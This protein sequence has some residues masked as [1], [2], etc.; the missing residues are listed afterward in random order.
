MTI[1]TLLGILL[2]LLP[3]AAPAHAPTDP[4]TLSLTEC[5]PSI[6]Q[7]QDSIPPAN[8][9]DVDLP[10]RR[11][12]L[13]L[14][15]DGIVRGRTRRTAGR[16]E[17]RSDRQW[18][19]LRSEVTSHRLER[20]VLAEARA[21]RVAL[22]DD[23]PK[24]LV[25]LARWMGTQG[26]VEEAVQELD[27]VL[28]ADPDQPDAL[29]L[30]ADP[31]MYAAM[32]T[33]ARVGS[34]PWIQ[35]L[36]QEGAGGSPARREQ[37]VRQLAPLVQREGFRDLLRTGITQPNDKHREFALLATRRLL[38]GQLCEDLARRAIL[39]TM[40]DVRLEAA[41]GLRDAKDPSWIGPAV[42]ALDSEYDKVRS[43]AAEALGTMGYKAAVEPLAMRLNAIAKQGSS[44]HPG[45]TRSNLIVTLETAYVQDFDVEIAQGASIADP[46]I[47]SVTSG[48][49]FDVRAQAQRTVVVEWRAVVGSMQQLTGADP[50]KGPEKWVDWWEQNGEQWKAKDHL[51]AKP[52][53]GD[54]DQGDTD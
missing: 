32:P 20:E 52:V 5:G 3:I 35:V 1:P 27:L 46:I 19:A 51:P 21:R 39:D 41:R 15:P 4:Q 2:P 40:Q 18:V 44:G 37:C 22:Q 17:E 13:H 54:V 8:E 28:G 14:A 30:I 45:G 33:D 11:R 6:L 42:R 29:E 53:T 36:M 50:G 38:P 12:I 16:W 31:C 49:I 9:C 47:Q 7:D 34:N 26:L 43:N 23:H 10:D 24:V 48:V 25:G